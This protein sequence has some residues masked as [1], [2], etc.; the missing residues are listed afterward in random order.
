MLTKFS[1]QTVDNFYFP[2]FILTKG[3]II[4]IHLPCGPYF[5]PVELKMIDILTG[6][7]YNDL[8]EINTPL[9]YVEHIAEKSFWHRFFPLT[10]GGYLDKYAN[11]SNPVCNMIYNTKWIT[12]KTKIQTLAGTPRRQLSL[13][14]TLS[15]TDKIIFDLA[16]VDPQGGQQIY[17]FVKT[18]VQS[19]GSAILFD[20]TDEFKDDCTRF[21]KAQYLGEDK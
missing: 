9:K 14:A 5:R 3:D 4:I 7:Q 21:I 12:P 15:W 11:K 10:V 8:I 13:Y 1:E 2:S 18:V 17:N 6:K 16:G 20:Y 19:G